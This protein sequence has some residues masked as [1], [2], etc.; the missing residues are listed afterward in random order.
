M[1]FGDSRDVRLAWRLLVFTRD[2]G[3]FDVVVD[4]RSAARCCI[5]RASCCTPTSSPS[6][7]TRARPR[8]GTAAQGPSR[9]LAGRLGTRLRGPNAWVHVRSR[10][11]ATSRPDRPG[12]R[13]RGRDPGGRWQLELRS[14]FGT[15]AGCPPRALHLGAAAR[16]T[17]GRPTAS[18]AGNQLFYYVNNFHDYLRDTPGIDFGVSSGQLR[19]RRRGPCP[20]RRRRGPADS[21]AGELRLRQ[22][23]EHGHAAGRPP[24]ADADVSC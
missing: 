14:S 16:P 4:A 20:G 11:R 8:A 5:A 13:R 18:Q 12:A 15:G 24:G 23:R 19:G 9:R 2:G 1:L 3:M 17:A 21:T 7:T 10:R 6:T 22:Q